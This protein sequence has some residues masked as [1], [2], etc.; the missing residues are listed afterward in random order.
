MGNQIDICH[1][2]KYSYVGQIKNSKYHGEGTIYYNETGDLYKGQFKNG[3]KHGFGEFKFYNGDKYTGEFFMDD[4]H[5]EGVY[6]SNNE[7][8][9]K[10]NFTFGSL[11]GKGQ[12]YNIHDE[13]IYDGEFLNSMPHGFGISY[14]NKQIM[15]VGNWIQNFYNGYGLLIE[16]NINK[17]GMFRE[18]EL[19]EQINKIPKKFL[20]YLTNKELYDS[21]IN[22]SKHAKPLYFS[23]IYTKQPEPPAPPL[24][25]NIP[26]FQNQS[27]NLTNMKSFNNK[28]DNTTVKTVYNPMNIR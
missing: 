28:S 16:N 14:N 21:N 13:L 2:D 17:Y 8:I 24:I 20:K 23:P 6:F 9:Y 25:E 1:D 22:L 3:Q 26:N 18:G 7:I 27:F 4:M 12:M 11:I 5:G 19:V 15:Y 10:G